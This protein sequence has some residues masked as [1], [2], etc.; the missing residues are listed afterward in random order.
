MRPWAVRSQVA[1]TLADSMLERFRNWKSTLTRSAVVRNIGFALFVVSFAVPNVEVDQDQGGLV[2][3][4]KENGLS[5]FVMTPI[6]LISYIG[7]GSGWRDV[8]VGITLAASWLT[9]LTIVERFPK[10]FA[11]IPISMPW[12]LFLT[13]FLELFPSGSSITGFL[14]FYVWAAGLGLF[15]GSVYLSVGATPSSTV[16]R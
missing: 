12:L 9:N 3:S 15:H 7:S 11:W 16:R 4:S 5:V 6:L 13:F 1:R 14:P 2:W 10:E 8:I